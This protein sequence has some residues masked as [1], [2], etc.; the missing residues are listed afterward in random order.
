MR[1]KRKI[2]VGSFFMFTLLILT[3]AVGIIFMAKLKMDAKKILQ[4]NYESLSYAIEMEQSLDTIPL[5]NNKTIQRFNNALTKQEHNITEFGEAQVTANLRNDFTKLI[6]GDTGISNLKIL[7]ESI[8]GI[9]VLNMRAIQ[10]KGQNAE[11][12]AS[13]ALT[14]INTIGGIVFIVG[15][16]F[17]I[18]FPGIITNPISNLT[19]AIKEIANKN[20]KHRIHI[21]NKDEFG[22]LADAFNEMAE[23]LEYFESSNLNKLLLE[24]ARA[25]AVINSLRDASIGIDKNDHVLFANKQALEL[26]GLSREDVANVDVIT[27]KKRNDLFAFLID[28]NNSTPFKIVVDNKENYF[29]KEVMDITEGD[30]RN[31]VI[32]LKNITSFK[33]LDV[34]KTNFIATISHELKTPL[35]SSDFSIKLLED[36]RTGHLSHE[37]KE[38]V[39]NLRGDNQRILKI[40]SELLNMAQV[41]TGNIQ[42]SIL[43]VSASKIVQSAVDAVLQGAKEKN[44]HLKISVPNN[45]P[46]IEADEDKTTWVLI[47]FLTN[48]IKYSPANRDIEITVIPQPGTV[49]FAV[50]D[51]GPGIDKEYLPRLFERYFQVPGTGQKG[52]GLGLAISKEFIEAQAGKI[53]AESEIGNGAVFKFSL[54]SL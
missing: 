31:K 22:T 36:E 9:L 52:T 23:R 25:E 32:V 24:K 51:H 2:W 41:E 27:L 30:T 49:I 33:E 39:Q 21:D 29:I 20:Y 38:L 50:A 28:N 14:I 11:K 46:D 35:A 10:R 47:N 48:A 53:W 12:T 17:V 13:D 18:N 42:L 8:Q 54:K 40:L 7:R 15:L 45:L 43:K 37:Q 6:N 3:A 44:I 26:L 5:V 34:A 16:T 4:D 19:K 1:V